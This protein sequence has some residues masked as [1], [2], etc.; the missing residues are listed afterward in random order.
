[1]GGRLLLLLLLL[2]LSPPMPKQFD[3]PELNALKVAD[4]ISRFA[5]SSF[6]LFVCS[7]PAAS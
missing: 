2:L 4:N 6:C 3:G 7:Y 1:V 5:R